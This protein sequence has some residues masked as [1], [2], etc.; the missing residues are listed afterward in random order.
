MNG[1]HAIIDGWLKSLSTSLGHSRARRSCASGVSPP[2]ACARTNARG[3]R[4]WP[5]L[6]SAFYNDRQEIDGPLFLDEW[7]HPFIYFDSSAMAEGTSH[8]YT[9]EGNPAVSPI[10]GDDGYYNFGRC[11]I[12]SVGPNGQNDGGLGLHTKEADD[13]ANF[14]LETSDD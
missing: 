8:T 14:T 4:S 2:R 9:I 1:T 13:I 6:P 7:D 5:Y 10:R 3:G 12:W 11:Q